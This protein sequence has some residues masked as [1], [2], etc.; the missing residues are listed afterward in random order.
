MLGLFQLLDILCLMLDNMWLFIFA[1]GQSQARVL[2]CS[3]RVVL[4]ASAAVWMLSSVLHTGSLHIPELAELPS[5]CLPVEMPALARLC[6]LYIRVLKHSEQYHGLQGIPRVFKRW[7][8]FEDSFHV[9][10]VK[11]L[12]KEAACSSSIFAVLYTSMRGQSTPFFWIM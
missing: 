2:F 9:T 5:I 6:S 10:G 8:D 3:I 1:V 7:Q 11:D 4:P 12:Y